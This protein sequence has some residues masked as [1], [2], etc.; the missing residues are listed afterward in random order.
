MMRHLALALLFG[1]VAPLALADPRGLTIADFHALSDAEHAEYRAA[2]AELFRPDYLEVRIDVT[3]EPRYIGPAYYTTD[4]G[5]RELDLVS[6]AIL[7]QTMEHGYGRVVFVGRSGSSIKAYLEGALSKNALGAHPG[8][9]APA[10]PEL[11]DLPYS[12]RE[13]YFLTADQ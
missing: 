4:E 1:L 6:R 5:K 10:R 12:N 3:R 8:T 13:P 9:K 11:S 2:L 7:R